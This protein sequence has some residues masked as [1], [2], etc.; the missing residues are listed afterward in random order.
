MFRK[1]FSAA[2]LCA[3]T[4]WG[5]PA[6]ELSPAP[7]EQIQEDRPCVQVSWPE[8]SLVPGRSRLWFNG[9]EVSGECLK[10]GNFLSFRPFKAPPAGRIEVR[11]QGEDPKGQPVERKWAF[12]LTPQAWIKELKHN[13]TA[14]LFEEDVLEVSFRAPTRGRATFQVGQLAPVPM[15]EQEKG[16]YVGSLTVRPSDTALNVPVVVKYQCADHQ[17]EARTA[18]P[19]KIFGGFY[20]VKVLSPPDGSL[21]DQNF[22]VTGRARKGS[23]VS[24]VPKI[25]FGNTQAP[26]TNNA[27]VS[28]N[29]QV[30]STA[31]AIP[32]DVDENG[33][34]Q[35]E[36]GVPILLPNMEVVMAIF[37]V[38]ADGNRSQPT[39]VRYRFK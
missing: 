17:E 22:T 1:M 20:R 10:S 32:A 29:T 16:L 13:A 6:L 30:S 24:V 19:V 12:Q 36:Y 21:V 34:F 8:G 7:D 25:G 31:G 3:A 28:G 35:V 11:F 23:R 38:D 4:A 9:Q 39:V 15:K 18:A 14:D 27:A 37:A 26:T 5:Q 33:N 2:V